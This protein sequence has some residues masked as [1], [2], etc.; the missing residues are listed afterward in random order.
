MRFKD[1][2]FPDELN[3]KQRVEPCDVRFEVCTAAVKKSLSLL[4]L[5]N[6]SL[7]GGNFKH[8]HEGQQ[9]NSLPMKGSDPGVSGN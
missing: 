4:F 2:S 7:L 1:G 9:M 6:L 8:H 5:K 3:A